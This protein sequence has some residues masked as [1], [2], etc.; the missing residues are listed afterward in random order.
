MAAP[1]TA[2]T[3]LDGYLLDDYM[4]ARF[5]ATTA[6]GT[7]PDRSLNLALLID[8]SGS[9]EGERL[10]AVQRTLHAARDLLRPTDRI[11]LVTFS[12][13]ARLMMNH[14][15]LD[16]DG[17]T[18]FYSTIDS[19]NPYGSTNLSAGL[20]TLF[21]AGTDYDAIVLLTDGQ[22]NLGITTT[23]GHAQW[24]SVESVEEPSTHSATV[25]TTIASFSEILPLKVVAPTP[26]LILMRFYRWRLATFWLVC[27]QRSYRELA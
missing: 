27:A 9:M 26:T 13:S 15:I 24:L 23:A 10:L 21:S 25:L 2:T 19:L 5:R 12:D 8:N 22:V 1:A 3:T 20:E 4:V 7:A 17:I 14:V 18:R 16:A 6:D 11:T